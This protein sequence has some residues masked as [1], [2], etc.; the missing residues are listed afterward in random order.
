VVGATTSNGGE[1]RGRGFTPGDLLA[2]IYHALGIDPAT[3]VTDRQNRPI[4]IVDQGQP[5]RELY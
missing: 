2:T 1:P 3:T 4:R 5:I